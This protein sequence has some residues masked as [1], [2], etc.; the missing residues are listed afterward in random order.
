MF[1]SFSFSFYGFFESLWQVVASAH[2][3]QQY[4]S[5][6]C[7][8]KKCHLCWCSLCCFSYDLRL[9]FSVLHKNVGHDRKWLG[10]DKQVLN[11]TCMYEL[12][13]TDCKQ[14]SIMTQFLKKKIDDT[15]VH[16]QL[17]SMILEIDLH[18]K[19]LDRRSSHE[20]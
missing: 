3:S 9:D 6:T 16:R 12:L 11:L 17:Y 10:G 2:L 7:A 18:I 13:F 19:K 15:D 1:S 4:C 5:H 20:L 14:L 8:L